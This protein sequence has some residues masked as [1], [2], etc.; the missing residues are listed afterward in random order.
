[1]NLRLS[2]DQIETLAVEDTLR[3]ASEARKDPAR[4]FEFVM[5]EEHTQLPIATLPH[6]RVLFSF[7]M[8]HPRC[9]VRMP[10]GASKTYS[11]LGLTLW[12]IGQ[13]L[14]ARGAVI[15]A[16][17]AQA[18]KVVS[19]AASYI[20]SSAEL[21]LVYPKLQPSTNPR[22]P[23]TQTKITVDRPPGIR[24]A[25]LWGVGAGGKLPGARLSWILVDDVNDAENTATLERIEKINRWFF[26]T[27]VT[28]ADV[29]DA[30]IVVTNTPWDTKDLVHY[31]E[32]SKWPVLEMDLKGDVRIENADPR[33]DTPELRESRKPLPHI[34]RL[35]A[36]DSAEYASEGAKLI[37]GEWE[38]RD[39][40]VSIWPE[41]FSADVVHELEH[42]TFKFDK[43]AFNQAYMMKC[44]NEADAE[45]KSAW[46]EACKL[47]ARNLGVFGLIREYPGPDPVFTGIDLAYGKK[48]TSHNNALF[49]FRLR[50][51]NHRQILD[52]DIGKWSGPELIEKMIELH[53]RYNTIFRVESNAA[54][55]YLLQFAR[56]RD[57]ALPIKPHVTGNNKWSKDFG[58]MAIFTEIE[59]GAW[60]IP[61]D[62]DGQTE[63]HVTTW[64]NSC[65]YFKKGA[66]TGDA[67]MASWFAR[68][69]ARQSGF[70]GKRKPK[71]GRNIGGVILSR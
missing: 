47:N 39:E 27:V 60:L 4:F 1:M 23:W 37:E 41:K 2:R 58:V 36:H 14:T 3:R 28:R 63:E 26:S 62:P 50:E 69:Q 64:I 68:E 51:D 34:S 18:S 44:R 29:K 52:V 45:C 42:V 31:L 66:H 20:E 5:K 61:N 30:R 32:D 8:A 38:D 43:A 57:V 19:A 48:S 9:V 12:L 46:V 24:D 65:L 59:N 15:S 10:V 25:T 7:V 35:S 53:R 6:Q 21:A 54:Q 33:W 16:G 56:E 67:L 49:T 22:D 17:E 70:I 55:I 71:P 40:V 11:M 13:D